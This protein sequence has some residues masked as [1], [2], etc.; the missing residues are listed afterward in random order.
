M[1]IEKLFSDKTIKA[2]EKTVML[3]D[4]LLDGRTSIT[5]VLRL[6][7]GAKDPVKGTCIEAIENVTRERPEIADKTC[8]D[9]VTNTLTD[10]AKRV[11]WE[12]A[13]VIANIAHRF[14][15]D[16]DEGV[17]NLLENLEKGGTVVRWSAAIALGEI[18]QLKNYKEMLKPALEAA[19]PRE[20]KSSIRKKL[21]A[22]LKMNASV[23][24]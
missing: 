9:F 19:I 4:A 1:L 17:T 20:E 7:D 11:Q 23:R 16:L 14:P 18:M 2:S 12:S 15:E 8:L 5:E 6:A 3:R 10:K 13:K 21:Q 22:A 24:F